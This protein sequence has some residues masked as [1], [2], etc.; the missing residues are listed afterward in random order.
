MQVKTADLVDLALDW[1]TAIAL[2]KKAE[3]I[4][5]PGY[6]GESLF[7]YMRDE[8][9]NLTGTYM[10]GPDLIYSR[11]W[12][13]TGPVLDAIGGL[14]IKHW[15]ESRPESCCEVHIHNKEG[16]WVAFG[17]TIQIAGLRCFVN[18]KLG[19]VVEI[20]DIICEYAAKNE[21]KRRPA[22]R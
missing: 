15:L 3:D 18:W 12:E 8:D 2:G 13:A 6:P 16:D 14:Q 7:T 19:D 4:R 22:M 9:G 21:Q 20:P 10:T 17:P 1:A 11:K 5:L